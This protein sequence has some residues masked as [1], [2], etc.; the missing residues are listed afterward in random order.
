[1]IEEEVAGL[2]VLCSTG[3][4]RVLPGPNPGS[5][6]WCLYPSLFLPRRAGL[7]QINKKQ[8]WHFWHMFNQ[9][10]QISCT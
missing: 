4:L 3:S 2:V 1:M 6:S 9:D 10:A 8:L 5:R 7:G